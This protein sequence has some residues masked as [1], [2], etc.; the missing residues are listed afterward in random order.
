[1]NLEPKVPPRVIDDND[2]KWLKNYRVWEANRKV[3][4][5]P[6]NWIEPELRDDKSPLFQ[7]LESTILQQEIKNDNVEAAFAD[8]LEG[9]D[10]IA[11]LDVRG[12]WFE[13]RQPHAWSRGR[14]RAV[15]RIPR[16][17]LGVGPRHVP[18]LRAHLQRAARL[19]LPPARERPHTGRRGRRSTPTSKAS[20]ACR[21]SS[22]GACTCS[23]RRS[24]R[25]ASRVPPDGAGRTRGRRPTVGQGLGDPAG[26]FRLRPRP[27]V[28]QAHVDRRR[29]STSARSSPGDLKGARCSTKVAGTQ[30]C[31]PVGL[32]AAGDGGRGGELP[33]AAAAPLLPRRRPWPRPDR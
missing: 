2:W 3:F 7:A 5:Y 15:L 1:M 21:S 11:R 17:A 13:Q 29:A 20:T 14:R 32:H 18:R 12:V 19:V 31:R 33:A 27:L 6:E 26:L 10:E 25:S 23:G 4:L 22:S 8:Y 24:A 28:A 16:A 30:C 9:L